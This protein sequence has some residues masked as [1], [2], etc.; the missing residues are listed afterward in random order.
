M[1]RRDFVIRLGG[2]LAAGTAAAAVAARD[3]AGTL[4]SDGLQLIDGQLKALNQRLDRVDE[5][6]KRLFR[7][8]VVVASIS[9][10]F[11]VLNLLKG[12]LLS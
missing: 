12:D 6:H 5:S 1:H 8:L 10:G 2:S 7:A 4:A 11:D 9:T 3:K